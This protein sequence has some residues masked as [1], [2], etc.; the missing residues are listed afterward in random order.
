MS[1]EKLSNFIVWL[2]NPNESNKV[3]PHK[4]V[5]AKRS[6]RTVNTFLTVVTSIYDYLY[7]NE[8][9]D[10][11]IVEVNEEGVCRCW[12]KWIQDLLTSCFISTTKWDFF[13]LVL[14]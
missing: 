14:P 3:V 2:R 1:F 7:R 8:L 5:T 4:K 13:Y 9:V 6:E 12:R 11:D 10:S